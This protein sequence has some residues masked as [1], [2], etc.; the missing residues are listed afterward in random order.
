MKGFLQI[1]LCN[2]RP[3]A[4]GCNWLLK[5]GPNWLQVQFSPVFLLVHRT[6]PVNTNY[7]GDSKDLDITVNV[8]LSNTTSGMVIIGMADITN[9]CNAKPDMTPIGKN[10]IGRKR[11]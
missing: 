2:Q 1:L 3:V 11:V 4:T 6:G 5:I 10:N 8:I 7:G 9:C